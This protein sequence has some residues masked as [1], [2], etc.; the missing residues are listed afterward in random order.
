MSSQTVRAGDIV[1]Y[2]GSC[3]VVGATPHPKAHGI[4]YHLIKPGDPS[5]VHEVP[6]V[7]FTRAGPWR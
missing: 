1:E 6:R 7:A 4:I 5:V 2:Q 3:W